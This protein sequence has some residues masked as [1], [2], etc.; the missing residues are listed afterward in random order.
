[1]E[2]KRTKGRQKIAIARIKKDSDCFA[3][4][5]KRRLGLFR[6]ASDVS[7][8]CNAD[9]AVVVYSPTG[10]PFSFFHPTMESVVSRIENPNPKTSDSSRL[11]EA[12]TRTRVMQLNQMIEKLDGELQAEVEREKKLEDETKKKKNRTVSF[13]E[14]EE[15]VGK[16][17]EEQVKNV[18]DLLENIKARLRVREDELKRGA[19][20]SSSSFL[21]H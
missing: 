18:T 12:Y 9:V 17:D 14:E 8:Q 16:F 4:F 10:K 6:K 3:T 1:M 11:F 21:L 13:W 2:R 20:S 15:A 19:S 5:S 7:A